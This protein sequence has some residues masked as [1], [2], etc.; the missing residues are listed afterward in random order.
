METEAPLTLTCT[1]SEKAGVWPGMRG[2]RIKLFG[3]V[4]FFF[5]PIP[6]Q[7]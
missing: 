5:F 3:D 2:G 6:L 4:I 7:V 1:C